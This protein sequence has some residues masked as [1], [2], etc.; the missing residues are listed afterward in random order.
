VSSSRGSG[1]SSTGSSGDLSLQS[2]L[3]QSL[4][5]AAVLPHASAVAV[6]GRLL[7]LCVPLKNRMLACCVANHLTRARV[8]VLI[9]ANPFWLGTGA[10][11]R[12][13]LTFS[14]CSLTPR[15]HLMNGWP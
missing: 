6:V 5:P 12:I 14:K 15:V 10:S 8:H 7:A 1:G 9:W 4:A 3:L 13:M 2:P 11:S